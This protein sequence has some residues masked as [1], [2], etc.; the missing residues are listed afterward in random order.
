MNILQLLSMESRVVTP[1]KP[2]PSIAALP[3]DAAS[4]QRGP[5]SAS[6]NVSGPVNAN[7]EWD[8]IERRNQPDRRAKDRR[9]QGQ[10]SPLDTRTGNDR[11]RDGRRNTDPP[12]VGRLSIKI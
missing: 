8:G 9:Q 3:E 4:D 12:S 1:S 6:G 10:E 11:R 2:S 5:P 7:I